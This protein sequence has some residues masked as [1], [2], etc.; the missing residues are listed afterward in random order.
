M[1]NKKLKAVTKEEKRNLLNWFNTRF[2]NMRLS[3]KK[4]FIKIISK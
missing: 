2:Q 1:L 3:D 4:K